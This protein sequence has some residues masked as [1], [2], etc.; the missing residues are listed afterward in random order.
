MPRTSR[1][2]PFVVASHAPDFVLPDIVV[3]YDP[4]KGEGDPGRGIDWATAEKIARNDYRSDAAKLHDA[5]IFCQEGIQKMTSRALDVRS[6]DDL[7]SGIVFTTL[8]GA[9]ADIRDDPEVQAALADDGTGPHNPYQAFFVRSEAKRVLLVAN[10]FDGLLAAS[11]ELLASVGYEVLGM[12][13]NW[14]YA[15]DHSHVLRFN[16]EKAGRPGYYVRN[17]WATSAQDMGVGTIYDPDLN[18]RA[19]ETADHS[20]PADETV[21]RSYRRWR[22]GARIAGRWSIPPYPGH[23]LGRSHR[24]VAERIRETDEVTGF[25]APTRLGLDSE[26]QQTKP[27]EAYLIWINSDPDSDPAAGKV[28][29]WNGRWEEQTD[30]SHIRGGILDLSAPTVH[31]VA[32]EDLKDST[33]K[34]FESDPDGIAILGI[35][36]EDGGASGE[37]QEFTA[38]PNWYPDYRAA[39]GRPFGEPYVLHGHNGLDQPTEVWDSELRDAG[40]QTN[41]MYGLACWLLR[42]YDHWIDSEYEK[43]VAQ[44]QNPDTDDPD[45]PDPRFTATGRSKKERVL[46]GFNSYNYHDV[47]PSF[48]LDPPDRSTEPVSLGARMRVQVAGLPKHRGLGQWRRFESHLD[49][50][51]ALR[52]IVRKPAADYWIMSSAVADAARGMRGLQLFRD[53]SPEAIA[54]EPR[55]L[56]AAGVHALQVETDFNFGKYGLGYYLTAKMLWNPQLTGAEL[57]AVRDRWLRR[58]FGSGWRTMKEYYDFM[59]AG[60]YPV[61]ST[62]SWGHAVNLIDRA[63]EQIDPETE[64]E[65]KLRIDDLKQ[66]WYYHYLHDTGKMNPEAPETRKFMWKGQMSYMNA[67]HALAKEIYGYGPGHGEL[68]NP[69]V[70]AGE[71]TASGPAHY[72]RAETAAWWRCQVRTHWPKV[73]VA[74]FEDATLADGTP[75]RSIDLNDLVLVDE[76]AQLPE[77]IPEGARQ[78]YLLY[79]NPVSPVFLTYAPAAGAQIGFKL[80]WPKGEGPQASGERDVSYGIEY[81]NGTS[82]EAVRDIN[83]TRQAAAPLEDHHLVMVSETAPTAG[84]YRFTVGRRFEQQIIRVRLG[85]LTYEVEDEGRLDGHAA[86]TYVGHGPEGLPTN[87]PAYFYIPKGT[88]SLDLDVWDHIDRTCVLSTG[89]LSQ[90]ADRTVDISGWQTHQIPLRDG[91]AGTVARIAGD[92]PVVNMPV[93]L[94]FPYLHSVPRLW[95]KSQDQLLVP[96]A[97]AIAD[98]LTISDADS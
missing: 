57:D 16:L 86:H 60:N 5:V 20:R 4:T 24:K 98:G 63:D 38:H 6:L 42:E 34:Q 17:L 33:E 1:H 85:P 54:A 15:P 75:A 8:E 31:H 95:A 45:D 71:E 52:L 48:N 96:R 68:K 23:A 89:L 37:F 82:W 93:W 40:A 27:E 55:T 97:I 7:S 72:T 11:E 67:M 9:T 62:S 2:Q 80:W 83:S 43:W 66:Y 32:L 56:H 44:Q 88:T 22:V 79:N 10:S 46:V 81:W 29:V 18:D 39:T 49:I 64:P 36:K 41:A 70:L 74:R 35:E 28:Y 61:N 87:R 14:I 21:D 26:R 91:E 25:L 51:K 47:L 13:P 50:A 30:P 19:D 58:A 65:A 84:I 73:E 94:H 69:A 53:L 12:G 76:F 90:D 77:L 3:Q 78:P 59:L 92:G